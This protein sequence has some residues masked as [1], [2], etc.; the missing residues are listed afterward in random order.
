MQV[1]LQRISVKIP[2]HAALQLPVDFQPFIDKKI[3]Q[4]EKIL[5]TAK[6]NMQVNMKDSY[7][8]MMLPFLEEP[9]LAQKYIAYYGGIRLEKLLILI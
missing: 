3:W 7:C 2:K 4:E 5:Y 1:D 8:E 6:K 9:E